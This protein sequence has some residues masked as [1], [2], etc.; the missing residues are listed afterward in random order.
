[1]QEQIKALEAAMD[2][3]Y[4]LL[5]GNCTCQYCGGNNGHDELVWTGDTDSLGE[6]E[7]WF[8]CHD[9]RD[10]GQSCETFYLLEIPERLT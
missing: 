5:I 2:A 10:K 9:C 4:A 7:V 1:M 3:A 6:H 8:C